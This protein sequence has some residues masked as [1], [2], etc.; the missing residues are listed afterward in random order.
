MLEEIER[1]LTE[2]IR[3]QDAKLRHS[4]GGVEFLGRLEAKLCAEGSPGVVAGK[5]CLEFTDDLL[6]GASGI[7][8][9]L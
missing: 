5:Q 9:P 8:S 4:A 3:I 6:G 2:Q 7:R 1:Y